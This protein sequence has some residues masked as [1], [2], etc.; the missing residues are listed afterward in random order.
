MLKNDIFRLFR[1]RAIK[2]FLLPGNPTKGAC[3]TQ[4]PLGSSADL[5]GELRLTRISRIFLKLDPRG[6]SFFA[7]FLSGR[8]ERNEDCLFECFL[9]LL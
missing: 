4:N 3:P 2:R 5:S 8:S 7:S 9:K 1:P 6:G